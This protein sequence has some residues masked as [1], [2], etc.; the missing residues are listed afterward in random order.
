MAMSVIGL[1][2]AR[3]EGD[4]PGPG[5]ADV[6]AVSPD[7]LVLPLHTLGHA[8]A[9]PADPVHG[10]RPIKGLHHLPVELATAGLD[11]VPGVLPV[12]APEVMGQLHPGVPP[13]LGVLTL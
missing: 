8:H 1:L 9:V 13:G 3:L 11:L 10:R 5:M 4:H 6:S 12:C 2:L 7:H